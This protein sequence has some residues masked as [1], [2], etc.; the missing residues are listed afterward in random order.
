[1]IRFLPIKEDAIWQT[2][3]SDGA[4]ATHISIQD[5]IEILICLT[6]YENMQICK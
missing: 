4:F 3:W 2:A 5:G 1:M 6:K